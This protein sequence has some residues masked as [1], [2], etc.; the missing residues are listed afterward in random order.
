MMCKC[1][2]VPSKTHFD[3]I[4]LV[5]FIRFQLSPLTFNF[6]SL[7]GMECCSVASK[8]LEP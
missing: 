6:N 1:T 5:K 7:F 8:Q 2:M 3:G 4:L